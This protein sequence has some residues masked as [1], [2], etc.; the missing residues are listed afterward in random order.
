MGTMNANETP[1]V[2]KEILNRQFENGIAALPTSCARN[3]SKASTYWYNF[4]DGRNNMERLNYAFKIA[5]GG[6]NPEL[7]QKAIIAASM[8]QYTPPPPITELEGA[9]MGDSFYPTTDPEKKKG[10]KDKLSDLFLKLLDIIASGGS[11]RL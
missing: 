1:D 11:M 8:A 2:I 10:M 6:N 9:I 3:V 5:T 4:N 7:F